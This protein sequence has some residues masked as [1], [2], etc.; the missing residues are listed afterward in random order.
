MNTYTIAKLESDVANAVWTI[1][2]RDDQLV[3][4]LV[5]CH[6]F[7]SWFDVIFDGVRRSE[8]WVPRRSA[9]ESNGA[10]EQTDDRSNDHTSVVL[11]TSPTHPHTH[12]KQITFVLAQPI[13][14]RNSQQIEATIT[15]QRNAVY[16][17]HFEVIIQF[18][19]KYHDPPQSH[20]TNNSADRAN[21]NQSDV[22]DPANILD[23]LDPYSTNIN[24]LSDKHWADETGQEWIEQ[25]VRYDLWR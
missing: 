5:Q 17:R 20:Q 21:E 9:D 16:R 4:G 11:N 18:K 2:A 15:T 6:G 3:Q 14:V 8:N 10:D 19:T 1:E 13:W 25:K 24:L 12:W 23:N 7:C 22:V